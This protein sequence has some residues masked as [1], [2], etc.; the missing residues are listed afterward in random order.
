MSREKALKINH[1][2]QD[3]LRLYHSIETWCNTPQSLEV[4]KIKKN[5]KN[6]E[7]F[8]S[9]IIN[10]YNEMSID[11]LKK[12]HCT[13]MYRKKMMQLSGWLQEHC[14]IKLKSMQLKNVH[15]SQ[16]CNKQIFIFCTTFDFQEFFYITINQF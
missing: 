6:I 5:K 8:W 3:L 2:L 4:S 14:I 15:H 12:N 11:N 1:I 13:C 7:K 10:I 16:L 9:S